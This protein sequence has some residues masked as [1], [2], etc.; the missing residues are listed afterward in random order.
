MSKSKYE[1][2]NE[3]LTCIINMKYWPRYMIY[4]ENLTG[5][6]VTLKIPDYDLISPNCVTLEKKLETYNNI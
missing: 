2:G 4:V 1:I 5:G 3:L 6:N